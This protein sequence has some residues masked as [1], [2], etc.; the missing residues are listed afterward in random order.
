MF[1]CK[2]EFD[3]AVLTGLIPSSLDIG[4]TFAAGSI[5]N[6]QTEKEYNGPLI[7]ADEANYVVINEDLW[8]G[9]GPTLHGTVINPALWKLI[10]EI[11]S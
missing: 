11:I 8:C 7:A 1:H 3:P 9:I 2:Q 10:N 4:N 5:I 6:T